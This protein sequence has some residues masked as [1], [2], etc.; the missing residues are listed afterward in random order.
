MIYL[1]CSIVCSSLILL[2]FRWFTNYG[3]NTRHAIVVNYGIAAIIGFT[4]FSIPTNPLRA[5]WFWLALMIGIGFYL[6]FRLIA[7]TTQTAGV[8]AASIATKMS[9]II[10]ALFGI[11]ALEE[12]INWL[13]ATGIVL[14]FLS[15]FAVTP[16]KGGMSNW[17]WP[18]VTFLVSG[19][20]DTS[21]NLFQL[22]LVQPN[23]YPMFISTIFAS[24][25]LSGMIHH[26]WL[27]DKKIART[28]FTG[29]LL[30]GIVNFGSLWFILN[31]LSLPNWESSVVFPVNNVGIV[32]LSSILAIVIFKESTSARG[33]LGLF[34][35][36]VSITLLYLSQ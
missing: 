19:I 20:I 13:K 29:G 2:L 1:I 12:G 23:A 15:V 24:A 5:S 6:G 3:A 4:F 7:K 34:V 8:S 25:F 22:T 21:L 31:V 16:S 36:I 28:S 30:L 11:I 35:S 27:P 33:L 14:G 9:M 32:A 18:I 10:P 26:S 17:V